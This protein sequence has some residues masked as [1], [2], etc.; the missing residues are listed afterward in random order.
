MTSLPGII[1][2]KNGEILHKERGLILLTRAFRIA[3][4][5]SLT[6]MTL[7]AEDLTLSYLGIGPVNLHTAMTHEGQGE[8]LVATARNE[9]GVVIQHAKICVHSFDLAE[10]VCLFELSNA[11]PWAPGT[12]LNWNI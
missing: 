6:V 12:E 4:V 9:S 1:I 2:A 3:C 5:I 7:Q 11:A 10:S 8:R